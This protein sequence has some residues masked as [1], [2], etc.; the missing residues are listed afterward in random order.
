MLSYAQNGEDVVLARVFGDRDDGYYLDVGAFL[1]ERGSVTKH[2]YDLG[3]HGIN[4]EPASRA[5]EELHEAR[6]RD[7]NLNI[8]ISDRAGLA[9][10]YESV[11]PERSTLSAAVAMFAPD[12]C[13][14]ARPVE[15]RTLADV[16]AEYG[17][18]HIEFL[19]IDVEGHEAE[20]IAGADWRRWRPVVLVVEATVP[21]K[22][23]PSQARWEPTLLAAD[24]EFALFDGINR[25][26]VRREDR[27]L[28][29]VLAVPANPHDDYVP[30]RHQHEIEELKAAHRLELRRLH[31]EL[32][33]RQRRIRLLEAQLPSASSQEMSVGR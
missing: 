32:R 11:P 31:E 33:Q 5:F 7:V 10:F 4:I 8:C 19:K 13:F 30:H 15:V 22:A 12:L 16:C 14:A 26:Y 6:P 23:I 1:P 28:L 20:V 24:Y 27:E 3:W 9:P 17:P 25:F 29:P 21:G 2:F 18:A